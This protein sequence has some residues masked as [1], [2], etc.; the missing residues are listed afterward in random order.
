MSNA[1][2]ALHAVTRARTVLLVSQP[3]Y[4][5]LALQL[6]LVESPNPIFCNTMAVDGKHMYY[7]PDFVLKLTEEELVGVVAHEV[8]H[9][10]YQHMIRRGNRNPLK[11]NIAGDYVIN[12]DLLTAGFKLPKMRLH[13]PKYK[14]MSTE[15]VYARLPEPPKNSGGGQGN[16]KGNGQGEGNDP[17][18][19]GG[20]IDAS[21]A[22]DEASAA[23]IS[24]E[25][26]ANVRMAVNLAKAANAGKLPGYLERLVAQ[27]KRPKVSWKELTRRFIDNSMT[28]DFTWMRPNR[29]NSG[30]G[31]LLPGY[32]ADRMHHLI[33]VADTSG[34]ITM[35]MLTSFLSECAGALDQ[36][37]CDRLT[38]LYADTHV[39]H[40]DEFVCG[41][42]V[43]PP[44]K[45]PG[46]GGTCFNDSF[47]WI[48]ENAPDAA[49]IVYLTDMLT[50]SFG[51]DLGIPTLWAAYMAEPMFE[52]V[53]KQ[54]PFGEAIH[55][56][57]AE[58]M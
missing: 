2:Q 18:Q 42:I 44:A 11:W 54:A 45:L 17:G 39:R 4:G 22:G 15:E 48:K 52:Q 7:Y 37:T 58:G 12:E 43:L 41:D 25:W 34:S 30:C 19:C 49:C 55:V 35:Q 24:A 9:C 13:D 28:K 26:E 14:G 32:I 21:K 31:V 3:F 50:S 5:S 1:K 46:G 57:S 20:V 51:E 47:R 27:L 56:D 53:S 29:R 16:N 36:G 38:V 23:A 6:Q 10:S 8:S 40:V 33:M